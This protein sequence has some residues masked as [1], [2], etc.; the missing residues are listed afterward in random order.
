MIASLV[1]LFP[2]ELNVIS[3]QCPTDKSLI[4]LTIILNSLCFD[5]ILRYRL[6]GMAVDYHVTQQLPIFHYLKLNEMLIENLLNFTLSLNCAHPL[7][8]PEWFKFHF[9]T[10]NKKWE[11]LWAITPHERLRLR[12][13]L[14]AI[15]AELYG[16]N[17]E[18]FSWILKDCA[19]QTEHLRVIKKTLDPK[20]FWRVDQT[21]PPELRH[22]VL[23]LK[24]FSDL[25]KMGLEKFC[26]LNGGD[27]WMIPETLTY[28]VRSDGTVE[29]DTPDGI[30]VPVRERLG[31]RF[32]DWQ[33]EGT[34]E[35]SWAECERHARAILGDEEFERMM[36]G[37]DEVSQVMRKAEGQQNL[38]GGQMRLF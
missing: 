28:A 25:K 3:L 2:A 30:T 11:S 24:A 33:L 15:I 19:Y 12:C 29:F 13:I 4:I 38:K 6:G 7:F 9:Q 26:A 16:L 21:E 27:G 20:G 37:G 23:A 31:P 1:R 22:T 14:D 32:L 5:T 35:E 36:N 18:D 17:Y 34:V 10:T 8:A